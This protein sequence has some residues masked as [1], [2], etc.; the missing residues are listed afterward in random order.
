M[1]MTRQEKLALGAAALGNGI[2][3]FSFMFSRI[4]LGIAQP[5]VMLMYRFG[6]TFVILL[7]IAAWAS[8]RTVQTREDGAIDWLRFDL[9]GR[10]LLPLIGLG[11]VQPVGYFL[12]ESYGISMTNATFSGVV[13]ALVPIAGMVSGAMT[14]G[15]I[16]RVKQIAYSLL[17][18]AGV[19]VMT[20]QQSAEGQILPLGVVLLVGAVI[21]GAAFNT[22]SRKVSGEYSVLERTVVMMGV[23][24]VTFTVLAVWQTGGDAAQ[25]LA[26]MQSGA[27][28][29]SMIYLSLCSSIVAFSAL[30]LAN[31]YL[32]VART[33]AFANLTT[34]ISLFA[35]VIFL[36]E[37]FGVVSLVASVMI[38]AG[39][40]GV[41]RS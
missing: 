29:T 1:G 27:F 20:M 16:P 4:A 34:V 22:I 15:E 33:T 13:I 36:G 19:V 6:M 14:L 28:L 12:C 38:L 11:I 18:I 23:A 5:F 26:P 10:K 8:R 21:T 31:N 30:N 17:S 32:P 35:G 37:P 9:R 7:G 41:Q 24:A 39:I 40:W 2:F 3:G 25:L